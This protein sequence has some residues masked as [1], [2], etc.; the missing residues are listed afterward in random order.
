MLFTR[1]MYFQIIRTLHH[2][3]VAVADVD[4]FGAVLH[5]ING[6]PIA[7]TRDVVNGEEVAGFDAVKEKAD[8]YTT[9]WKWC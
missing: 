9:I 5:V 4:K 3:F 8:V 6:F 2:N 1:R 7:A